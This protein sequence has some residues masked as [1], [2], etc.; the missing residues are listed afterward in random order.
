MEMIVDMDNVRE[1]IEN[2]EF[3]QFLLNHTTDFS[4]A[5]WVLQTLLEAYDD[6]IEKFAAAGSGEDMGE[7]ETPEESD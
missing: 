7:D 6:A 5:G 3:H 1:F 2:E 4:T